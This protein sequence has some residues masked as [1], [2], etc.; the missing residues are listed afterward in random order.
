M[1]ERLSDVNARIASARQIS[2]VVRRCAP[3][4]R[5]HARRPPAPGQRAPLRAIGR[6]G[7]QPDASARFAGV[8]D[9]WAAGHPGRRLIVAVG[10]EQ[11]FAG[12]FSERVLRAVGRPPGPTNC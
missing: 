7:D 1:T 8:R 3:S 5:A 6:P 9:V 2:S 12:G 4:R 10:A 11:G